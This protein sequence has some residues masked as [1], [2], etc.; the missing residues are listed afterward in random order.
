MTIYRRK[1]AGER[2]KKV[3]HVTGVSAP[4]F[5]STEDGPVT[6]GRPKGNSRGGLAA[7]K[8]RGLPSSQTAAT[9]AADR[10]ETLPM[11]LRHRALGLMTTERKLGARAA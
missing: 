10:Y 1:K 3:S 2:T 8:A 11:E 4:I 6:Q 9:L 5:L 7:K